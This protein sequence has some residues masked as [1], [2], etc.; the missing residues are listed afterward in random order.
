LLIRTH[1]VTVCSLPIGS[2]ANCK[3]EILMSVIELGNARVETKG[4]PNLPKSDG[5]TQFPNI[6][7]V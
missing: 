5:G 6:R 1:R 7:K 2:T 3:Q 4:Q